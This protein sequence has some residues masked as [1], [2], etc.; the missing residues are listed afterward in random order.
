MSEN[1]YYIDTIE[2]DDE[3]TALFDELESEDD[4]N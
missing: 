2:S 3:L 4:D 1:R